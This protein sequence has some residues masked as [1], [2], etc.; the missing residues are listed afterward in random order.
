M[1]NLSDKKS[2]RT[3]WFSLFIDRIT[4]VYFYS[5]GVEFIPPE[6]LNKIRDKSFNHNIFRVQDND[7]NICGFYCIA[8]I[9]YVLVGKHLLD[10]TKLFSLNDYKMN[11]KIIHKCF[12]D[13]YGKSRDE[14]INYLLEKKND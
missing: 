8:F 11:D 4:A 7:S 10:Y 9:E 12:K 14:I 2:K 13:K 3:S 1:I 6:V 5:F